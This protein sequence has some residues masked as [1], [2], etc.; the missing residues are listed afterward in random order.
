MKATMTCLDK[1]EGNI[2]KKIKI[3]FGVPG[4]N[5]S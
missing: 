3:Q 5:A 4:R 1:E 2:P